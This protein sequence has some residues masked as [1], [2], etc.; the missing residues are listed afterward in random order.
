MGLVVFGIDQLIRSVAAGPP[1]Q[2][3]FKAVQPN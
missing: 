2:R 3:L 1:E